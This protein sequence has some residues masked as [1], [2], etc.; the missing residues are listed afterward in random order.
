MLLGN[1]RDR[2]CMRGSEPNDAL[3]L[4]CTDGVAF[5]PVTTTSSSS[6]AITGDVRVL[7]VDG[8]SVVELDV[9]VRLDGDR[10]VAGVDWMLGTIRIA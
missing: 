1:T 3:R 2:C 10:L 4:R 5:H 9:D 6:S 7:D 8:I